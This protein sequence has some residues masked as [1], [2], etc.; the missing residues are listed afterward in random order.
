MIALVTMRLSGYVRTGRALP[1]LLAGLI[2]LGVLYGGGQAQ[3][4]EA[5]GVSAVVLFPV[6]AWQS[7]L[8]L[9]VEPDVQRRL[10]LVMVGDR[11][12][13]L[14]AGL[15][16]AALV[17]LVTVGIALVMPWPLNGIAHGPRHPGDLPLAE[18][19]ALGAWA[20]LLVLPPAVA[21]GALAS[22]ATTRSTG[23]GVAVL[24]TGVVGAIVLGLT[25]SVAPWLAPPMMATARAATRG[26]GVTTVTLL[27]VHAVGW[28]AVALAGYVWLRRWRA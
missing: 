28:A 20:H 23:Y 18:G 1:P 11:R 19:M 8:L 14:A 25:N 3:A 9:D 17:G 22:R 10:A 5:Y 26:A 13:E 16:A 2:V 15:L 24:A 21:L 27:T 6:L 12:R 7:K 4:G